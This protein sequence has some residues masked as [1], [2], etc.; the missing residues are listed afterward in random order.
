MRVSLL[1]A[2]CLSQ[3]QF[4]QTESTHN[5]L[6]HGLLHVRGGF[7][8]GSSFVD[9][10][11]I[12]NGS[13]QTSTTP[14]ILGVP[15]RLFPL[16]AAFMFDAIA[17]GLAMPLLPFYV[18]ELGANAFQLS[19]IVSSNY[20]AQMLGC[21]AVG[22]ISDT[23]GRKIVLSGALLASFISYFG[24]SQ[25]TTLSQVT[26]ARLI[27]GSCGGL[28]PIVQS[29]VAD[30]TSDDDRPTYFARIMATYGLGFVL[31]PALSALL[32][33][34]STRQKLTL[35]SF[36]PL[37]GFFIQLFF[38]QE[39]RLKTL[40]LDNK[41]VTLHIQ[42]IDD[43]KDPV[44]IKNVNVVLA[45]PPP[46][47]KQVLFLLING[48]LLM[49]AFSIE[50]I[51]AMFLKDNFGYG[52]RVLSTLFAC[53]GILIGI[54]QVFFLKHLVNKLG[55]HWTLILGNA[56]LS[57]GMIGLSLIRYE[58]IHFSLFVAHIV[59]YSIA[60][61]A[62]ASLISKY[63][64]PSTQ[65][66]DLSYNQAIQAS[67]RVVSPLIAGLLYEYSKKGSIL[68]VGA[69]PY[70]IGS[71]FPAAGI[72]VPLILYSRSVREKRRNSRRIF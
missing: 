20:I 36:F 63:S 26:L 7:G 59:G 65:G 34:Y 6:A 2:V 37:T 11:S 27:V 48:F 30:V 9:V 35:A 61:T 53:N 72:A 67:A 60:D 71:L 15:T 21:L 32:P 10:P 70:L 3:G 69:L 17:V 44:I 23:Y 49:Y 57:T 68:P 47:N 66:R 52:E 58:P 25:S 46:I 51:Y 8:G 50:T 13:S 31:G 43:S 5:P 1:L 22:K 54:F 38:F 40:N 19:L 42:P 64:S 4:Q 45:P 12:R 24:V 16:Y 55:K 56:I 39:T 28:V 33:H 41:S 14:H 62:L 29:G 18:M